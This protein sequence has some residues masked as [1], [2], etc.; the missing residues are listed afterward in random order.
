ME[1]HMDRSSQTSIAEL[2]DS[3]ARIESGQSALAD[4][5]L[6]IQG[7]VNLTIDLIRRLVDLVTPS[8]DSD[9]R[10][11]LEDVL[12]RLIAQQTAIIDL[13]RQTLA[14]VTRI[15]AGAGDAASPESHRA[16]NKPC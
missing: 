11:R 13:S 16:D 4:A 1:D 9:G 8:E 10:P 3:I 2:K 12:S 6:T 14:C 7:Q 15:E 5:A